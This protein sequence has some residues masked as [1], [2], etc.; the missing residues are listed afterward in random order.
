LIFLTGTKTASAEIQ[1]LKVHEISPDRF[2]EANGILFFSGND[3]GAYGAELWKTD[4]TSS[5]TTLV[6]DINPGPGGSNPSE[7]V[8]FNGLLYFS[9]NDG[10]H[11]LEL[12]RSDGTAG[13]T[14]LVKD[15]LPGLQDGVFNGSFF[16]PVVFNGA[17]YF[18]AQ[19]N[20]NGAALWKTD[21]TEGGTVM[22][23]DLQPGSVWG[24]PQMLTVLTDKLLF[25]GNDAVYGDEWWVSDG[26]TLGTT[27]VKDINSGI[28]GGVYFD[29]TRVP[30][31]MDGAVYFQGN[32]R[33]SP[34]DI[35]LW[36]T[37]GTSDGTVRV[38]NI[39]AN[40]SGNLSSEPE[41]FTLVNGTLFFIA[42]DGV[43]GKELWKSDGTE[44]GTIRVKDINPATDHYTG[45]PGYLTA[46]GG[47]LYFSGDDGTTGYELWKSD[48]T[49]DG[50]MRVKDINPGGA[51]GYPRGFTPLGSLVFFS[52]DDGSHGE[53]FWVTDGT[54]GNTRLFRDLNAGSGGADGSYPGDW[55]VYKAR[56]ILSAEQVTLQPEGAGKAIWTLLDVNDFVFLPVILK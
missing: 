21:G 42:N 47:V 53:E 14:Q 4:G 35:E 5:G 3:Y 10:S 29:S 48:G 20:I 15:I 26:T 37:D 25:V 16:R 23:K 7:M 33:I 36:K 8:L 54:E 24:I 43:S 6:K 46:V 12:W 2:V 1:L 19:D 38:K 39:N 50:T 32:D 11:G 30:T 34:D 56:I 49:V 9:A 40:M 55:T 51:G 41:Q 27:M 17:L 45:K 18:P 31:L 44:G 52:A 13:G 22:V 28:F